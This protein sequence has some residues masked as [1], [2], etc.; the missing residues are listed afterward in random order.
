MPAVSQQW[1]ALVP[2]WE[3]LALL[4][5]AERAEGMGRAPRT[6]ERM[7]LLLGRTA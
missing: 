4:L 1:A 2:H 5:D 6:Y 7:R 3:S